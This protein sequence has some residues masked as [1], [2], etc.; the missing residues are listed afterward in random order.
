MPRLSY[1]QS[2]EASQALDAGNVLAAYL[3]ALHHQLPQPAHER[4]AVQGNAAGTEVLAQEIKSAQNTLD[5]EHGQH[6]RQPW[7]IS[8]Q[9]LPSSGWS[10]LEDDTACFFWGKSSKNCIQAHLGV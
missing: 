9:I 6:L 7:M 1:L 3:P 10:M 5:R 2:P 4:Q 8:P